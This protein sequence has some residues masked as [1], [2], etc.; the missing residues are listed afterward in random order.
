MRKFTFTTL[1]L[2]F[3]SIAAAAQ[4]Y[5]IGIK[6]GPTIT[7][8]KP[9]T[10]GPTNYKG[11]SEIDFLVGAFVDYKFKENYHFNFGINYA[12][13]LTQ[14]FIPNPQST[15]ADLA[16]SAYEQDFLQIPLLI[17]LYTNEI[18]LDTKVYFNFG[19]IPEIRVNNTAKSTNDDIIRELRG[20][21]IAGNFGGGLERNIG[22]NT[23]IFAG[24]FYNVGFIN[25]IKTQNPAFDELSLKNRLIALEFGI[26]F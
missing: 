18:T 6:L 12:S 7:F 20:F 16:R 15:S 5:T 19:M 4:D 1:V 11:E 9:S 13:K 17:K 21:D 24:F 2:C 23:S 25:Q 10:E 14:V 3:I 26:K 8:S 22:V